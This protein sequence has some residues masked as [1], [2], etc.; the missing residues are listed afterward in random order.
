V[1]LR[2]TTNQDSRITIRTGFTLIE[3]LIVVAILA[4]LAAILLPALQ[5]AKEQGKRSVCM[6][7][8]RQIGLALHLYADDNGERLPYYAN[9]PACNTGL[10]YRGFVAAQCGYDPYPFGRLI[11]GGY[12]SG[13]VMFCPSLSYTSPQAAS[14]LQPGTSTRVAM[15]RWSPGNTAPQNYLYSNYAVA[16][17]W[18]Y[19]WDLADGLPWKRTDLL[20]TPLREAQPNWPLAADLRMPEGTLN[21]FES[22][23]HRSAG[24]NVVYVDGS[25]IWIKRQGALNPST[26]DPVWPY[27][28]SNG[29]MWSSLWGY[30]RDKK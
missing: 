5:N 21:S 23:N 17:Q 20:Q 26:D 28:H 22:S 4:M 11:Q 12:A 16:T 25:V 15:E 30:F 24:F 10:N 27:N 1:K 9:L 3:L 29:L 8:L 19:G 7:N 6:N 13:R 14:G 2:R 18:N